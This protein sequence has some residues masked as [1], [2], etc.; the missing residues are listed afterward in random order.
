[1][2]RGQALQL[3]KTYHIYNRGNNGEDVFLE[4]RNYRYFLEL[5]AHHIHPITDTYAYCLMRNHF[6]LLLRVKN[7]DE[8]TQVA[9]DQKS[10]LSKKSDL[11]D[12]PTRAFAAFF[13]AYT[14]GINKTYLRTGRLFQEHFGRIE[15][16]SERYFTNLVFYIHFNPQRHKFVPDFR[17]W[18]WSSYASLISAKPTRLDRAHVVSWFG[19][20]EPLQSFH[21][22]AVDEKLISALLLDDL[23]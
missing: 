18:P 12:A 8:L 15:V 16:D 1:M 13:T 2:R 20:S 17:D 14:K 9:F 3:G 11:S 19:G 4:E 10:E 5:Y 22:G 7:E 6:H 21:E 23:I